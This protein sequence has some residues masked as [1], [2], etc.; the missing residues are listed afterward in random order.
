MSEPIAPAAT[1][2]A[3]T[4]T[5]TPAPSVTPS[6]LDQIKA[7]RNGAPAAEPTKQEAAPVAE[8][9]PAPEPEKKPEPEAKPAKE[10]NVDPL[11]EIES[12]QEEPEFAL[13][14]D[15][16]EEE[17]PAPAGEQKEGEDNTPAGRRIEA[18]KKEAKEYKRQLTERDAKIAQLESK[19]KESEGT[20]SELEALRN[21]VSEY[22]TEFSVVKLE[23]TE[24]F[25]A[26]VAKPLAEI[27]KASDSIAERY[28]IDPNVLADTIGIKDVDQRR[29]AIKELTAGIEVDA[30]DQ[31]EIRKLA[32]QLNPILAKRDDLY[33]NADRALAE[34]NAKREAASA[35][36]IAAKAEERRKAAGVVANRV[37]DKLSFVRE[38]PGVDYDKLTQDVAETDFDALPNH[39]RAYDRLAGKLLPK[40]V[41]E[42]AVMQSQLDALMDEL[43][44]YKKA[45]PAPG[46]GKQG[47][48]P[49]KGQTFLD[50]ISSAL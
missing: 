15:E 30:D 26:A 50:K 19:T 8:T 2:A 46:A 43:E 44:G 31:Y 27:F 23:K 16:E 9:T 17:D 3:P 47:I 48:P 37:A 24:A 6:L 22:E 12:E 41:K 4:P 35:A 5:P 32:D 29:A 20:V 25:Q 14:I 21:K 36:E 34:L 7:A 1:E 11:K 10:E 13:P 40:F 49:E 28:N 39:D 45:E 38:I 18:L 42:R 33:A